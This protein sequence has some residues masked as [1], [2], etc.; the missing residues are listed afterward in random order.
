MSDTYLVTDIEREGWFVR[1]PSPNHALAQ[2]FDDL[3]ISL[4]VEGKDGLHGY[5]VE[6]AEHMDGLPLTDYMALAVGG[7]T[8]LECVCGRTIWRIESRL[9]AEDEDGKALEPHLVG[10]DLFCSAACA[11]ALYEVTEAATPNQDR[12]PILLTR[13]HWLITQ[14]I[15]KAAGDSWRRQVGGPGAQTNYD[16]I[17]EDIAAQLR[18]QQ[19]VGE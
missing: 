8:T 15:L 9:T 1:A 4:L 11:A 18:A 7:F 14:M 3:G 13:E 19:E 2:H 17:A 6:R 12:T 16:D 10:D 5:E